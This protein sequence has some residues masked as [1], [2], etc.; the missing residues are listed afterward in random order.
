[1]GPGWG[2]STA[3]R[4]AEFTACPACTAG[5][6][7]TCRIMLTS[8]PRFHSRVFV[9]FRG[10]CSQTIGTLR[11][12]LPLVS[13]SRY[14]S[15]RSRRSARPCRGR[16]PIRRG[17]GLSRPAYSCWR[18]GSPRSFCL[19]GSGCPREPSNPICMPNRVIIDASS[20]SLAR[21]IRHCPYYY[22]LLGVLPLFPLAPQ[23]T[24]TPPEAFYIPPGL[25]LAKDPA[26]HIPAYPRTGPLQI[27][28]RKF[29]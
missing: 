27:A 20:V 9:A 24:G 12:S 23:R 8:F 22:P 16:G 11:G 15:D 10:F 25:K 2:K 5:S 17:S 7:C 6:S 18:R 13:P 26:D 21:F 4:R 28:Q 19:Q 29:P 3:E 14:S 1:L